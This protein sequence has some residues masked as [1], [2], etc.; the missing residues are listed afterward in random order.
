M[1][2]EFVKQFFTPDSI[3]GLFGVNECHKHGVILRGVGF[4]DH[5]N[6]RDRV[7]NDSM[8]AGTKLGMIQDR[9]FL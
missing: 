9:F 2:M 8:F 3:E 4:G 5:A 6:N 7:K 1:L